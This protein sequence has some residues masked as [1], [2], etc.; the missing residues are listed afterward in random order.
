MPEIIPAILT[1]DKKVFKDQIKQSVAMGAKTVQVDFTDGKFVASQTLT[2]NELDSFVISQSGLILE[3]HL[4]VENPEQYYSTLYA[5]G[6]KRVSPH[7]QTLTDPQKTIDIAHDLG[8]EIGIAINPGIKLNVL[9]P[10]IEQM[11]FVL[12]LTVIPGEQGHPFV[13]PV[14]KK[15]ELEHL[16]SLRHQHKEIVI[17]VDGGIKLDNI[18]SVADSG[19][20]RIV[21]GSGIWQY[22]NSLTAFDQLQQAI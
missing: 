8:L 11:D 18:Q 13:E 10:F 2:P 14:L 7:F 5:L 21:V 1:D 17:E 15:I 22:S 4:M 3:A 12:F 6:F 19:A 20:S 16:H 9:E